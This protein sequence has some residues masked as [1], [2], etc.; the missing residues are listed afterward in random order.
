MIHFYNYFRET[1][2]K[3]W[4]DLTLFKHKT[5]RHENNGI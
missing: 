2:D 5:T 1:I 3:V 4:R